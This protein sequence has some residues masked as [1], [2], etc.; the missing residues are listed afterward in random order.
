MKISL[1]TSGHDHND[2]RIFYHQA[3]T[4]DRAGYEVEIITSRTDLSESIDG[5]NIHCFKSDGLS[6]HAKISEFL[7]RLI[8]SQPDLLICSEPLPVLAAL[9]YRKSSKKKVRVFYD[10]TEWYPSKRNLA[11]FR[12]P[13]KIG[14]FIK[15]F[16]FNLYISARVDGFIFGEWY[17]S[18]LYRF[19]FP[20]KSY[21]FSTYYPELDYIKF[22]ESDFDG[23]I[24]KL[25]HSGKM[26]RDNGYINFVIAVNILTKRLPK[27]LVDVKIIG[28]YETPEDKEECEQYTFNTSDSL[29]VTFYPR[30]SYESYLS[31]IEQTH[32]FMD[33]RSRDFENQHS[34][35]IKLFYYL[36]LGRPVIYSDLKSIRK[37]VEIDQFG[38]LVNPED[39]EQ[40]AKIIEVYCKDLV[41]YNKHCTNARKYS[42]EKYNWRKIESMFLDFINK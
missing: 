27:L 24:L 3:K 6:K 23:R 26:S 15:L 42:V 32:L 12:Y 35:P 14:V 16:L 40:I 31:L 30:Q 21:I 10:I 17:K 41:L 36:S 33:L 38:K 39:G 7:Q 28:W 20:F 9:K 5:I 25:C 29:S 2:D 8:K 19:L 11:P 22:K 4:L 37:E 34:L 1:L 13:Y 18:R